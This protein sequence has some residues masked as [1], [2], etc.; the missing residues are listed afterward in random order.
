M[1]GS[2][3]GILFHT[4]SINSAQIKSLQFSHQPPPPA[5]LNFYMASFWPTSNS[6][7][8]P[9]LFT[10][11]CLTP[12]FPVRKCRTL[13][14]TWQLDV[15]TWSKTHTNTQKNAGVVLSGWVAVLCICLHLLAD[16]VEGEIRWINSFW[17]TKPWTGSGT[18][19]SDF[20]SSIVFWPK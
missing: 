1:K 13:P 4:C 14:H 9:T 18:M 11:S 16:G 3:S 10:R 7:L 19:S 8:L 20:S 15:L 5:L 2:C 6:F 12:P 17:L